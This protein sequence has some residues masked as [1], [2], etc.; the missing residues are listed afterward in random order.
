MIKN[1]SIKLVILSLLITFGGLTIMPK[2]SYAACKCCV[3]GI[4]CGPNISKCAGG[5]NCQSNKDTG[6]ITDPKT[7]LG[8]ITKE[9]IKHREWIMKHLWE[10]HTLPAMMLMTEQISTAAMHQA[11]IIGTFFDAKQQLET[12]R[13]LQDMQA[14][15]HKEY[16]PSKGMC[17]INTNV[18]SLA[19]SDRN[20]DISQVAISARNTQRQLLSS[21]TLAHAGHISD[22]RS[23]WFQYKEKYCNPEDLSK[24]LNII[25]EAEDSTR[26]RKDVNFSQTID[27]SQQTMKLDFTNASFTSDEEDVL[28]L[29]ANLYGSNLVSRIGED[30]LADESGNIDQTY[31]GAKTYLQTRSL[32]AKRSVAFAA[33]AAQ[34]AARGEGD[35][36]VFPYM[37][38]MLEEMGIDP[39]DIKKRLGDKPSYYAQME[40]L[41]K[42]LYQNPT[43]YANLY[44][45][46]VNID[47]KTAAMQAIGLMQRR[48]LYRS[49]LRS[50]AIGAVLLETK[51]K[52]I[53]EEYSNEL[54]K[55]RVS[56]PLV[57]KEVRDAL[58]F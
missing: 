10:A 31:E 42:T 30:K 25:C 16:H 17:E 48:D 29:A 54:N 49:Q 40:F 37:E 24:G 9:F 38:E 35:N 5:C 13:I 27:N 55:G 6:T 41:T 28:A 51:L 23:R 4:T 8:R 43:F 46:P 2:Q 53:N 39:D 7:S 11:Q 56:D 33:Y 15:A 21:D 32:A 12:Q 57:S 20:N 44:D 45:K 19:A 47:R 34:A 50:E 36:K 18:R 52:D 14:I 1:V 26:F 22:S 3:C 58:G